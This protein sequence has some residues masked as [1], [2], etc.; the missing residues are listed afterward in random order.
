MMTAGRVRQRKKRLIMQ[1]RTFGQTG[2]RVSILGFGALRLPK[3]EDETCDFEKSVPLLQRGIDLGINFIDT[4]YSYIKGT[5]EICVGQAIKG[6]DRKRLYLSTKIPVQEEENAKAHVWRSKF[7]ECLRRLDTSYIDFMLFHDLR[8]NEFTTHLSKPGMAMDEVR[9]ARYEGLVRHICF[10]SHDTPENIIRLADTGEFAG[11]LVQYNFLYQHHT[12]AIAHAARKGLGVAVM[13]PVAGGRLAI[14]TQITAK[15]KNLSQM[16]PFELALRFVWNNP[17]IAAAFSGM[18]EMVQIEQN[19]AAADQETEISEVERSRI[20]RL[21]EK[22]K[23][24]ADLYC[25]GCGYC[26]P[27][28]NGVLIPEVFR[29]VNWHRVWGLT[30]EAKKA[31]GDLTGEEVW[32]PW[33]GHMKGLKA[34]A[35]TQCGEC[36][37]KCPQKISIIEQLQEADDI[38]G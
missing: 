7:E 29:Y 23:H 20:N 34:K 24:L 31:Y 35:C 11:M 15:E 8:W 25:T 33:V 30:A 27:C 32:T 5:S 10:S 6:Y 36:E 4:A 22:F 26:L 18:S 21:A 14:P 1:Y 37:P 38:L 13:G 28:P 2:I 3:L 19:V 9:K 17:L 12:H 16:E